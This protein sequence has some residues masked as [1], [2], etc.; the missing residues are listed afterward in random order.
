[1]SHSHVSRHFV[2][3]PFTD[4]R[5]VDDSDGDFPS[6]AFGWGFE[7]GAIELE[8]EDTAFGFVLEGFATVTSRDFGHGQS[9]RVGAG[10][11]FS[12]PGGGR[13]EGGCGIVVSRLGYRGMF[14]IG[15][16]IEEGGRLRY[17]D[18]CTDSLLIP[19]V[20]KGDPC[21]NHLHFPRHIDQTRH[22]H[23]SVCIGI[24]A[25]GR[26]RCIVPANDDG[27]GPDVSIPLVPG[28]MFMI[29]AEGQHSFVTDDSTM[30]VIAYHPDSD[31]GP[32]HD[33]HPMVNRTMVNGVSAARIE[34]L[35][36]TT[37]AP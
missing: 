32:A 2:S 7:G 18:G 6:R 13:V 1:M 30:D 21:F 19:P 12:V 4:S 5:I 29:P 24:V 11:Y 35:R 31:M 8:P 3:L 33:D 28:N 25:R 17:I 34:A 20:I 10:M 37:L 14:S 27:S 23:P 9:F 22:T 36:T 15:G 26:G 16:P